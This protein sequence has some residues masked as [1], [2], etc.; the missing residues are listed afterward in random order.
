MRNES[1]G[2]LSSPYGHLP[3]Y[4]PT[5][6]SSSAVQLEDMLVLPSVSPATS[7]GGLADFCSLHESL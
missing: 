7:W 3:W 6:W 5:A 1:S 2:A 4:K